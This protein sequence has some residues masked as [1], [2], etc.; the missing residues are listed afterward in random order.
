MENENEKQDARDREE[1]EEWVTLTWTIEKY[2]EKGQGK[3][4]HIHINCDMSTNLSSLKIRSMFEWIK[5]MPHSVLILK[6]LWDAQWDY[7][8]QECLDL[9]AY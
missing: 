9:E 5:T 1:E 2:R 6:Q 7:G 3:A 4:N 8:G